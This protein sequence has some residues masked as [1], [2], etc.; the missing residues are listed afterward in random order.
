[1]TTI[2]GARCALR[3]LPGNS[4]IVT[5]PRHIHQGC[6]RDRPS[7]RPAWELKPPHLLP[8]SRALLGPT[9]RPFI[10]Q[11]TF[12]RTLIPLHHQHS[13]NIITPRALHKCRQLWWLVP[14][15]TMPQR[16]PILFHS[17]GRPHICKSFTRAHPR[18]PRQ[19]HHLHR[20]K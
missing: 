20:P 14:P 17:Q 16:R 4:P 7:Q 18:T 13:S 1:M 6:R 15:K 10:R 19:S 11:L 2:T 5:G 12:G 9:R 3:P 8:Q